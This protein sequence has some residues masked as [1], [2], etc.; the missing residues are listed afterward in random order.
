MGG[1]LSPVADGYGKPGLAAARD[2]LALCAAAAADAAASG[3]PLAVDGWEASST[4]GPVRSLHVLQSVEARLASAL[5]GGGSDADATTTS[6][7]PPPTPRAMLLCGEDV[8]ASMATPGVWAEGHVAAILDAHGVVCVRRDSN[9]SSS[10]AP[11]LLAPGGALARHAAGV[12]LVSDGAG[13]ATGMSSTAVR[14]EVAAGRP[15][16]WLVPPRVEAEVRA[17]R[18]YVGHEE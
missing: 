1:Y 4:A 3:A 8:L 17:R 18:L 6:H 9:A 7:P 12:V 10:S 2:R 13:L 16:R 11:A 15:L 5:A 14:A